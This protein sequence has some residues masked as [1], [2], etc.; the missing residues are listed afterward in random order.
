MFKRMRREELFALRRDYSESGRMESED[1]IESV[2]GV[3]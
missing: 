3:R 2:L 1:Y